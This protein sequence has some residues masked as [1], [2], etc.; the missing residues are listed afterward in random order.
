MLWANY[1]SSRL[2][3]VQMHSHKHNGYNLHMALHKPSMQCVFLYDFQHHISNQ[4]SSHILSM[5]NNNGHMKSYMTGCCQNHVTI[6]ALNCQFQ[7]GI[8]FN[9]NFYWLDHEP[10]SHQLHYLHVKHSSACPVCL[11]SFSNLSI[12]TLLRLLNNIFVAI[13]FIMI[14]TRGRI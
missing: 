9:R 8:Y 14:S 3:A 6:T 4:T 2:V 1:A 10:W 5:Y 13:R 12:L 7:Q 11:F